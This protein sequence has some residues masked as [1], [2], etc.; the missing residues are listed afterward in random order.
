M[1]SKAQASGDT[2]E[3]MAAQDEIKAVFGESDRCFDAL[4]TKY[5]EIEASEYLQKEV[6]DIAVQ[7][8]PDPRSVMLMKR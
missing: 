8:C 4:S 1:S 7:Q 2:S 6:M 5:P 3:L